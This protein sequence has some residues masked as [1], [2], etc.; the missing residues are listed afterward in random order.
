M[1]LRSCAFSALSAF[2]MLAHSNAFAADQP[3]PAITNRWQCAVEES[4]LKSSGSLIKRIG[5]SLIIT[6]TGGEKIEFKDSPSSCEPNE[7][8]EVSCPK[9][10]VRAFVGPI[11]L[12]LIE[13]EGDP[14]S[15][16]VISGTTGKKLYA[17]IGTGAFSPDGNRVAAF[18]SSTELRAYEIAIV[19]LRSENPVEEFTH[20][21]NETDDG[22]VF[23]G[24]FRGWTS[25]TEVK[26]N[27]AQETDEDPQNVAASAVMVDGRWA[28]RRGQPSR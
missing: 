28:I 8:A 18:F 16:Q 27:I 19:D 2:A 15:F 13:E 20:E 11:K 26:F 25:N 4:C 12:V 9:F 7:E 24:E 14:A 5:R 1:N 3:V 23:V 22:R 10:R 17:H 6:A 21:S